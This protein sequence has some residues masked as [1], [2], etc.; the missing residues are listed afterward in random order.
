MPMICLEVSIWNGNPMS[1]RR[2]ENTQTSRWESEWKKFTISH[3]YMIFIFLDSS[4]ISIFNWVM[5]YLCAVIPFSRRKKFSA[6]FITFHIFYVCRRRRW[7]LLLL[8]A[9]ATESIGSAMQFSDTVFLLTIIM[10]PDRSQEL[11][12]SIGVKLLMWTILI[13]S[14]SAHWYCT[15]LSNLFS[16]LLCLTVFFFD[17]FF[18][19]KL[20]YV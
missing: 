12:I 19:W 18:P 9:S 20:F 8:L 6:L 16:Y 14:F 7:I 11:R 13:Y 10:L 2:N 3:V 5:L 15:Y 4:F 1:R 17:G